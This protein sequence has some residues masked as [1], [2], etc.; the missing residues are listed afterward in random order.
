LPKRTQHI[1]LSGVP[2]PSRSLLFFILFYQS[3]IAGQ[4]PP[5]ISTMMTEISTS[6]NITTTNEDNTTTGTTCNPFDNDKDELSIRIRTEALEAL[7]DEPEL[8]TLL[9]RTILAPGVET[10]E[11]A[12]AATICYRL[13]LHPCNSN[14]KSGMDP[15]PPMFCPNSLRAILRDALY[16]TE[17]LELGHT[18]AEAVRQDV[19][20][21]LD[22]DPACETLLEVVL[23]MK[24]FA[25]L[26]C[27]RAARQKWMNSGKKR[28]SMTALF[29]QSRASAVFGVDIHPGATMGAGI[30][31]DHGTGIVIGETAVVGDGCTLLHGVTLGGNG[32]Q[33]GDRHPKI[34]KHVLIGTG[35]SILG[36]IRVGDAA[37][38]GAGSV[39]LRAIPAGAT[40]VGAPAKI[41]GRALEADPGSTMDDSLQQVGMLQKSVSS[42][43]V[44]TEATTSSSS[45]DDDEEDDSVSHGCV[46]PFRDYTRLSKRAPPGT[47]TIVSLRNLLKAQGCTH[48]EIGASFFALDTKNV[49]YIHRD[50]F[51]KTCR[52]ALLQ[53]TSLSSEQI[54]RIVNT[55]VN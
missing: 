15:N 16:A 53:N 12:V 51:A 55:Y 19:L 36:N 17:H 48:D 44:A 10:F 47:I 54:E 31:L 5:C 32:K 52:D 7:E 29:L 22:R 18:M 3:S 40:A 42:T 26:V 11:D 30:L 43:T 23:F 8:G 24:G 38:I 13:I 20:A 6:T 33:Q 25:A 46:C 37:K 2:F 39:V 41:I 21:V 14:S 28:R 27:H 4:P 34:G 1:F 50:V 45:E 35:A 9:K 49:G